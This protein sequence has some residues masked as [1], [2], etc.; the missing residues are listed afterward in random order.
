MAESA[1]NNG[2]FHISDNLFFLSFAH[3]TIFA[4]HKGSS[5]FISTPFTYFRAEGNLVSLLLIIEAFD[6]DIWKFRVIV[7]A[8]LPIFDVLF[9]FLWADETVRVSIAGVADDVGAFV[10]NFAHLGDAVGEVGIVVAGKF[11][12]VSETFVKVVGTER[13]VFDI[14]PLHI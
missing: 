5:K 2:L 3:F 14:V 12:L 13:G 6:D 8:E 1:R 11:D 9:K 10:A 4:V 7:L